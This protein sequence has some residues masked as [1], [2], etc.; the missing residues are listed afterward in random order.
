MLEAGK[1]KQ[2]AVPAAAIVGGM[3]GGL[4]VLV[5]IAL[6]G[7]DIADKASPDMHHTQTPGMDVLDAYRCSAG[8][9][10]IQIVRGVED[11]FSRQGE[12]PAIIRP[13]LLDLP[14]YEYLYHNKSS[15]NRFRNFDEGGVDKTLMSYVEF[16]SKIADGIFVMR[17]QAE[18]SIATDFV[19][20]GNALDGA[21]KQVGVTGYLAYLPPMEDG[22]IGELKGDVAIWDLKD[23]KGNKDYSEASDLLSYL[24]RYQEGTVLDVTLSDDYRVDFFGFSLCQKPLER[25]GATM[26]VDSRNL[27]GED[28]KIIQ[29]DSDPNQRPCDPHVG[30]TLCR[31]AMPLGCYQEGIR[32][33]RPELSYRKPHFVGGDIKVTKPIIGET[34]NS[35]AEADAICAGELGENWRTLSWH[36]AGGSIVIVQSDIAP[37]TRMWVDVKDKPAAACW[38]N[39]FEE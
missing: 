19:H 2:L 18:G 36:E 11:G 3:V 31:Q 25:R 30:D 16:P 26:S 13:A 33:I 27:A 22:E 20:I 15:H 5:F 9:K 37:L 29:C 4:I 32:P 28:L 12:E 8:Q 21:K 35:L 14:Y 6:S 1:Y 24:K 10:K 7:F 39:G 34:I 17:Y 38:R 23:F